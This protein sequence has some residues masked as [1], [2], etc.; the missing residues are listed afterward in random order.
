MA[1]AFAQQTR[2]RNV[3]TASGRWLIEPEAFAGPRRL[4]RWVGVEHLLPAAACTLG[5]L[6]EDTVEVEQAG[7]QPIVGGDTARLSP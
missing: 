6:G 5:R 7:V 1:I 4:F 3:C 2:R